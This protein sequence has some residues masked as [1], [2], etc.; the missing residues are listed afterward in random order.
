MS[1]KSIGMGVIATVLAASLGACSQAQQQSGAESS[2]GGSTQSATPSNTNS[3]ARASLTVTPA[4][5]DGC[6]P[7]QPMVATVSWHA[8]TPK[9]KVLVAGPGQSAPR[10]FSESGFSGQAK[11]EDWVV[12]GTRFVLVNASTGA[13]LATHL[14]RAGSCD[15]DGR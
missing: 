4:T 9:V 15:I 11:T 3:A 8:N 7:N 12:T 10:L 5:V 14:M 6:K 13:T 2:A 1:V